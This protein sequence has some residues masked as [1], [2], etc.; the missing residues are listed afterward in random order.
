MEIKGKELLDK[1]DLQIVQDGD[2]ITIEPKAKE[3]P[4]VGDKFYTINISYY[5]TTAF[6]TTWEGI[7][8]QKSLL[9]I[10]LVFESKEDAEAVAD[11]INEV[12]NPIIDELKEKG[13]K[14]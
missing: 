12:V 3:F 1:V 5:G 11:R 10:G 13:G 14:K 7:E 4:S 9:K 2:T 6:E 8:W